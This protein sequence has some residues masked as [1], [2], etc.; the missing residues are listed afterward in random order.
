LTLSDKG[1]EYGTTASN[2]IGSS[3]RLDK[4]VIGPRIRTQTMQGI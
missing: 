3:I 2:P 1:Q 4:K